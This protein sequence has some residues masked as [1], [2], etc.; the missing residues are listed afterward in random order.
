MV[1]NLQIKVF[2]SNNIFNKN[3]KYTNNTHLYSNNYIEENNCL[4]LDF[5]YDE[6]GIICLMP[7]NKGNSLAY[8]RG[9]KFA[10]R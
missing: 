5:M 10:L 4:V 3:K 8:P 2:L 7:A 9:S 6:L 1:T